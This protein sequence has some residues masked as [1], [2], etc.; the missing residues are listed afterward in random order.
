MRYLLKTFVV[1]VG[2][3]LIGVLSSS[4]RANNMLI[5]SFTLAHAT[6]WN[7]A[8]LPAG[9]YTFSVTRGQADT[10]VLSVHGAKQALSILIFAQ[11]ACETCRNGALKVAVQD[12]NRVVTSLDLPGF[13]L[14]FNNRQSTSEREQLVKTPATSEQVAVHVATN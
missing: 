4:V 11:S 6:Q 3:L 2:L 5:G 8:M 7:N 12:D 9:D 14:N 10:H 1:T 13:H